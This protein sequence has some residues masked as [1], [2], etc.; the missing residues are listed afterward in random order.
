[1]KVLRC[2]LGLALAVMAVAVSAQ[3]QTTF[4]LAI[5]DTGYNCGA[6]NT[7]FYCYGIP[8]SGLHNGVPYNGTLFTTNYANV[9]N[10]SN[11]GYVEWYGVP[12]TEGRITEPVTSG[13][14]VL[15][16]DISGAGWSGTLTLHYTTKKVTSGG[17][18][19]GTKTVWIVMPSSTLV[20]E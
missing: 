12:L 17:R 14:G 10:P 11:E 18:G 6:F 8:V 3:A 1:M 4:K 15:I 13:T 5:P 2:A 20:I 16:E 19:G 7:S 9:L